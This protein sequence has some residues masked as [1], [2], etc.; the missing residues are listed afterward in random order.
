MINQVQLF[1]NNMLDSGEKKRTVTALNYFDYY[2]EKF[3]QI[4]RRMGFQNVIVELSDFD[5]YED[6]RQKVENHVAYY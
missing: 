4:E 5:S 3:I 6:I 2:G 1:L